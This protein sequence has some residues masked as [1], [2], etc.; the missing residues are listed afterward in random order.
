MRFREGYHAN[1]SIYSRRSVTVMNICAHIYTLIFRTGRFESAVIEST[2]SISQDFLESYKVTGRPISDASGTSANNNS[3][4]KTNLRKRPLLDDSVERARVVKR[5]RIFTTRD[6]PV[7]PLKPCLK[8]SLPVSR[9]PEDEVA[10][11][12]DSSSPCC[13]IANAV[14]PDQESEMDAN[15]VTSALLQ[16]G[17]SEHMAF[18]ES[19]C[20]PKKP[21]RTLN[22]RIEDVLRAPEIRSTLFRR[23]DKYM[24]KPFYVNR[25][26]QSSKPAT[27]GGKSTSSVP[28]T[29]EHCQTRGKRR[30]H[31][32]AAT[33]WLDLRK[34]VT[35]RPP[36]LKR[37]RFEV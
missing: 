18:W 3:R 16:V 30:P 32:K 17:I 34:I 21:G 25:K 10:K 27:S 28:V 22:L 24:G 20:S 13:G 15:V 26:D 6:S 14:H 2:R 31:S 11:R 7:T 4:H 37:L 8:R 9:S 23:G 5:S 29:P 33:P 19:V 36:R 35:R 1:S 12:C